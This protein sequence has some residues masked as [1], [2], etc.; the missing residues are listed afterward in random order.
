MQK[1]IGSN[2]K[3][4]RTQ[5]GMTQK[6]LGIALGF[7]EANADV[8]IAQ[9]ESGKRTPRKNLL[10]RIAFIFDVS[11]AVL[12]RDV[13]GYMRLLHTL[14]ELEDLCMFISEE[15]VEIRKTIQ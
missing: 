9:Y 13:E 11:P 14:D 15:I 7:C 12:E 6:Q 2:I 4:L 5:Y 3:R 8:R 1:N 10:E